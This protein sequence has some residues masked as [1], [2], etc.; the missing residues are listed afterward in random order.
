MASPDPRP[1]RWILPVVILGMVLFTYVFVETVP[2]AEGD[3]RDLTAGS[4]SSTTTTTAEGETPTSSTTTLPLDPA[5]A[6]FIASVDELVTQL[7]ALQA[8]MT[9]VNAAWDAD[10]REIEYTAAEAQLEDLSARVATWAG[11]VA[12]LSPPPALAAGHQTLTTT[13]QT[14]AA[15]AAAVLAGLQGPDAQPRIDALAQFNQA[16]SA[17]SAAADQLRAAATVPPTSAP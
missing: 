14:T 11:T 17:V 1:G 5:L 12:G 9:A 10:P 6:S 2:G 4:S 15:A 16:A 13:A 7:T 3:G 8:E